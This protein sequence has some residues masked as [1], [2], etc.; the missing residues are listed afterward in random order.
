M[1]AQTEQ[2]SS[3]VPMSAKGKIF[4]VGTLRYTSA[5]LAILFC[6]LLWGDFCFSIFEAVLGRF[7]PLY[8]ADLHASNTLIGVMTGSIAGALNI[9]FLPGISIWSDRYRSRWGRRIPFLLWSTPAAVV[10][11]ILI[12]FAP[13]IGHHFLVGLTRWRLSPS[14]V[15]LGLLCVFVVLFHFS[16]MVLV[17]LFQCLLRDVVP[18]EV[19]TRFLSLFRIVSAAG[20]F[21]FAWSILPHMLDYRKEVCAGI[22]LIYLIAF[23]VMCWR[24][25]EGRYPPPPPLPERHNPATLLARYFRDCLGNPL[26]RNYVLTNVLVTAGTTSAYPFVMLFARRTLV[27]TMND[28]GKMLA[29]NVLTSAIAYLPIGY[30][31]DKITPLP[32]LLAS[33]FG[34]FAAS[35]FALIAVHGK[36]GW[37]WYWIIIFVLPS[38]A[39]ALG[40]NATTMLIFPSDKFGQLS[41]SLNVI[42]FGSVIFGNYAAG[43]FIDATGGNYRMIFAWSM[44]W[45]LLAVIPMIRVLRACRRFPGI[46]EVFKKERQICSSV[47]DSPAGH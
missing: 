2:M 30:L 1:T 19:M 41:S 17:N 9:L 12:G 18:L 6:W 13:E 47:S 15:T 33:L 35:A 45:Y 14:A 43:R 25:K 24:V 40:Q 34:M 29:W 5:G 32:V 39:W 4:T 8:M 26:Y 21:I 7:L 46:K 20:G 44:S 22:G 11:L 42:G 27:L 37:E 10:S 23:L 3:A 16:N 31:C 38:V 36:A 28:I